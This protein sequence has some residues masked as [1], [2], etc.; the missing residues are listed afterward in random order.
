MSY[1]LTLVSSDPA[2]TPIT[3]AH[4]DIAIA[5]CRAGD[6][7]PTC[8]PVWL[9]PNEA[10][11]IGIDHDISHAVMEQFHEAFAAFKFDVF[12]AEIE[13]RQK[14]LLLADMDSTIVTGETLDDLA[15]Y[16]GLKDEVAGIT[17]AAMEGKLDFHGAIRQ[18]VRLLKGLPVEKLHE[19]LAETQLSDGALTFVKTMVS[20]GAKCVLVSGGFSFFTEKI[21]LKC[22]FHCNHGN[23]LE[24]DEDTQ[25]LTGTVGEPILD[26]HAKEK[27]LEHYLESTNLKAQQAMSIGDGANDVPMLVATGFGVGY[28]PKPLV[29]ESVKNVI[30]YCDLTAAL[31]AQ[32]YTKD[33]FIV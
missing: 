5:L 19:T 28:R 29:R 6:I 8:K 17:Q 15:A 25:T 7:T 22:G 3:D 9:S 16:A 23:T 4:I 2:K 18:R 24:I 13:G 14:K 26:K 31:F 32:G 12:I 21:S 10:V 11:D 1:V 27:F 30:L 20:H 33:K